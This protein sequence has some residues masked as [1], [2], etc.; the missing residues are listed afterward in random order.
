MSD[1]TQ[2]TLTE[3]RRPTINFYEVAARKKLPPLPDG[4]R[5]S[6]L[7]GTQPGGTIVTL[8]RVIG[9]VTRGKRKG[10]PKWDDKASRVTAIVSDADVAEAKSTYEAETGLC[11]ECEGTQESWAGWSAETGTRYAPC[12]V[13]KGTGVSKARRAELKAAKE[14]TRAKGE[15]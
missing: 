7:D 12:R 15:P 14:A 3:K 1:E 6:A 10:A 9:T 13:C 8:N 11:N 5:W 2:L 4:Y